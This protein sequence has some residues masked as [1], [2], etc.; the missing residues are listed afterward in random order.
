MVRM[1]MARHAVLEM[2]MQMRLP[3]RLVVFTLRHLQASGRMPRWLGR[4]CLIFAPLHTRPLRCTTRPWRSCSML[5]R[6]QGLRGPSIGQPCEKGRLPMALSTLG[7]GMMAGGSARRACAR[8][9]CFRGF[10]VLAHEPRPPLWRS[11]STLEGTRWWHRNT[12]TIG[13]SL[14]A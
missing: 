10:V 3:R 6:S 1:L 4:Q 5:R 9:S 7:G 2:M 13:S 11:P 14:L 12:T 8:R